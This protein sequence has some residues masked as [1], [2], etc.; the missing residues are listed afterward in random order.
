MDRFAAAAA[1]LRQFASGGLSPSQVEGWVPLLERAGLAPAALALCCQG[2][3]FRWVGPLRQ[4]L[5]RLQ[6]FEMVPSINL[7]TIVAWSPLTYAPEIEYWTLRAAVALPD[8][9]VSIRGLT[10]TGCPRIARLG[11]GWA[12]VGRLQLQ[13]LPGLR[14]VQG[15]LE[16]FGDLCLEGLPELRSLGS[17]MTVHGNLTLAGCPALEGLPADIRVDGSV[18]A[19]AQDFP[20]ERV[21]APWP[22]VQPAPVAVGGF[23]AGALELSSL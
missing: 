1:V 4:A 10:V 2:A 8:N 12:V 7:D 17:Q 16:V 3:N 5:G 18:W 6:A 22:A 23:P 14:A 13:D 21:V 9:L 20:G 11:R 15:P 19:D